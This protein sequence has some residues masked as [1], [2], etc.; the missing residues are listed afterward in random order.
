MTTILAIE[1]HGRRFAIK[2]GSAVLAL[3]AT[4]ALAINALKND[5]DMLMF[6]ANSA[7]VSIQNT[8]A[9]VVHL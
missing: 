9:R 2:Y 1:K 8:P 3:Y 7:G 6:W 5:I 4:E